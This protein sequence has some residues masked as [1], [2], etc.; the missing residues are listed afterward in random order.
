M[1]LLASTEIQAGLS[2]LGST[3]Y[4]TQGN[5]QLA[6]TSCMGLKTKL[7]L[8]FDQYLYNRGQKDNSKICRGFDDTPFIVTRTV[9]LPGT[10]VQSVPQEQ[11]CSGGGIGRMQTAVKTMTGI[12]NNNVC[13]SEI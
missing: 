9:C 12:K 6:G 3:S 5:T 4:Y 1:L 7:Y 2:S 13:I 11:T 8:L 10:M